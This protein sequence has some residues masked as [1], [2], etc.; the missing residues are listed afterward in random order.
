MTGGQLVH[1]QAALPVSAEVRF[2]GPLEAFLMNELD[3]LH[4][5]R[6]YRRH[7]RE[8]FRTLGLKSVADLEAAHLVAY[9]ELLLGD[10][11]GVATH[12]QA[13]SAVRSFLGWCSDLEGLPMPSRTM[14]RLLR[15][16]STEVMRPYTTLNRGEVLELLDEAR[17]STRNLALVHVLVGAGLRVAEVEHLD[18]SDLVDVDGS[19]ALWVRE[20]KGKKDRLVP[21]TDE[22]VRALHGYLMETERL[23][24]S[25]GPLFL[26]EDR[27]AGNDGR[28]WRLSDDGIRRI[29][30]GMVREASIAK[31][32]S[33]HTLRHTFGMEFQRHGRD[34]NLTAKVLGHASLRTTKKYVDHLELAE[35]REHLPSW[36]GDGR[37]SERAG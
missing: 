30:K 20:G 9:R 2:E 16:P 18:C 4:S 32:V 29:L 21:I 31:V 10:G 23:V 22:V 7:V 24:S 35:I 34:M 1:A 36:E 11:R 27:A 19:P 28:E 33:P 26:R 25:P 12:A 3:S 13:L 5:R 8:A 17:E 15:V 6:A 37:N 14:E